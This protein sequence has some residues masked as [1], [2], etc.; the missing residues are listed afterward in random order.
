[1]V[2]K[3][4]QKHIQKKSKHDMIDVH[5]NEYSNY[6]RYYLWT[7]NDLFKYDVCA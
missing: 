4:L 3:I 5:L 1:M 2:F 7:I 6:C